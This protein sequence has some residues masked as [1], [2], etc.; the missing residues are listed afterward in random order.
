MARFSVA[1]EDSTT[2]GS[3]AQS[4]SRNAPFTTT[5]NGILSPD[6]TDAVQDA[7]GL[8]CVTPETK[9]CRAA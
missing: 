8:T 7:G 2:S 5:A 1:R 3:D 4:Y 6:E 9:S